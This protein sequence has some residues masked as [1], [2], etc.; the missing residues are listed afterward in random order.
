MGKARVVKIFFAGKYDKY[1][2][3]DY[4]ALNGEEVYVLGWRRLIKLR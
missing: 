1:I 4:N 3:E 2:A